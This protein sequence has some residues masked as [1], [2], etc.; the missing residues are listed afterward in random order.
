MSGRE[1]FFECVL[2]LDGSE[3]PSHVRAW[4]A[5]EAEEHLRASL[6][7]G[8]LRR[9]GTIFVRDGNGEL[10]RSSTYDGFASSSA[11]SLEARPIRRA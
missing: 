8:G 10:L 1:K 11:T 7:E 5:K 2:V 4:D 3:Y 6:R 9:R